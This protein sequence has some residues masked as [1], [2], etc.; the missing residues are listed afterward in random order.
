MVSV[1]DTAIGDVNFVE[2]VVGVVPSVVKKMLEPAVVSARLTVCT[3]VKLPPAGE[4][5][6]VAA[7]G[8]LMVNA[9]APTALVVKPV[10]VAIALIVSVAPTVIA[11]V[12][13][14]EEVVGVEPSAWSRQT[15]RRSRRRSW[16]QRSSPS[17]RT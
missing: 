10:A 16:C 17:A 13:G 14:V 1:D 5:I 12:Y 11:P 9:P 7:A 15:Y 2:L 8:R 6:G 4:N 3:E